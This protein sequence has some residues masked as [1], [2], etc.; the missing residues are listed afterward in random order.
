MACVVTVH[1]NKIKEG[2]LEHKDLIEIWPNNVY[3]GLHDWL[4]S[5]T[6]TFDLTIPVP[7]QN[8]S[9]VPCLLPGWIVLY[10]IQYHIQV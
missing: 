7:N 5:L 9:I 3:A 4:H 1:K 2:K 6:E 8:F 10:L